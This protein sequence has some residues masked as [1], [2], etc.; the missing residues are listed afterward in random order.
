MKSGLEGRN[1]ILSLAV[2]LLQL[3]A[4]SMKSGLEGRNNPL[5]P[6]HGRARQV[7][8]MKCGLVCRNNGPMNQQTLWALVPVSM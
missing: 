5:S 8:S 4:V 3:G 6:Q 7:V 2:A 1:N